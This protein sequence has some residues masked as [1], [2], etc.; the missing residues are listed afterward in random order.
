MKR[1]KLGTDQR[2]IEAST[3]TDGN[4]VSGIE[5]D[6]DRIRVIF[7]NTPTTNINLKITSV[8]DKIKQYQLIHHIKEIN[9][10]DLL[11]F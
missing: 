7:Y 8:E 5:T 2:I 4:N 3:G 1:S 10:D 9:F 11:G 6:P